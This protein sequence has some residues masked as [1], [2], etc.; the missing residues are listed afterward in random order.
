MEIPFPPIMSLLS[1]QFVVLGWRVQREITL[2]EQGR[3]TWFLLEDYGVLVS[4]L[5]VLVGCIVYPLGF[6]GTTTEIPHIS[7]SIFAAACVIVVSYP[8]CL[9]AHY[10]LVIGQE[11]R[12]ERVLSNG[13]ADWAYL[14]KLEALIVLVSWVGAVFA[15]YTTYVGWSAISVTM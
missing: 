11:G 7:R 2:M 8:I 13:E 5:L 10:G 12:P 9:A 6:Q 1:L 4:L 3:A 15:A 14:G